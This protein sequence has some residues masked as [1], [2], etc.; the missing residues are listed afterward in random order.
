MNLDSF[1]LALEAGRGR[2]ES[3]VWSVLRWLDE[4]RAECPLKAE[5]VPLRDLRGWQIDPASGNVVHLTGEF[6]S[7]EGVRA[8]AAGI[9]EVAEWDQ[10]ILNQ[11]EGGVLGLLAALQADGIIRFLL[12]CK[13]EPGNIG[14]VQLC[15]TLQATM[16]NLRRVHGGGAPPLAEYFVDG[17]LTHLIYQA[18][19]NE[20]GGRFWQKSNVNEVRL[21]KGHTTFDPKRFAWVTLSQLKALMLIDNVVSPFVKTILAPL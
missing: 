8:Y 3:E 21:L 4:A 6:F 1:R 17:A 15:P 19:H 10:P 18:R 12:S 5:L 2:E 14:R 7:V 13:A 11:K 20:E 16:S 9:R